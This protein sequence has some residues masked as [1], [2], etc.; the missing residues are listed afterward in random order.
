MKKIIIFDLDNTFY[1]YEI[2]HLKAL[3]Q[4]FLNQK[5]INNKDAFL[6]SYSSARLRIKET[7]KDSTS[8]NNRT[9]Y[10]KALLEEIKHDDLTVAHELADIY[11]ENFIRNADINSESLVKIRNSKSSKTVFHL[12]TNLNTDI[13][14]KKI[15]A[16]NLDFFDKI[17]TSEDAGY[18]KPNKKFIEHVSSDLENFKKE[19]YDFFAV[20]D[21]VENDLKPW[22]LK[23]EAKTFL[24]NGFSDDATV[25]FETTLD[26]AIER[27]FSD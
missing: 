22:K 15:K 9:L 16:W 5:I 2:T 21:S 8:I 14:L 26:A 11:W 23:F 24:I 12:Y 20:G 19:G 10:F 3:D 7:L 4:V 1:S 13:Q 27:I 6:N 17:V 18:E 25:D